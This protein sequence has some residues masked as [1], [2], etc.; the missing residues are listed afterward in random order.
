MGEFRRLVVLIL[1][2]LFIATMILGFMVSYR[3]LFK[4]ETTK[5]PVMTVL[6]PYIT[7]VDL[8]VPPRFQLKD[9][10]FAESMTWDRPVLILKDERDL[11]DRQELEEHMNAE[12]DPHW[13]RIELKYGSF[14]ARTREAILLI[15]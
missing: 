5:L 9:I 6:T 4:K 7:D 1:G 13:K 10:R 3:I 15:T 12:K 8:Y 11:T 14:I 2:L